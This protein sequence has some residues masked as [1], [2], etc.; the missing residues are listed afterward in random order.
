MATAQ[1]SRSFLVAWNVAV[2]DLMGSGSQEQPSSSRRQCFLTLLEESLPTRVAI[3]A[4]G[5]SRSLRPGVRGLTRT[6]PL[7]GNCSPQRSEGAWE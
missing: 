6:G 2:K 4:S 1:A 5:V 3:L 7:L